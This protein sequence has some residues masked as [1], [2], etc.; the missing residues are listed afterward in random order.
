MSHGC[1]S[2]NNL[3][4]PKPFMSLVRFLLSYRFKIMENNKR[5]TKEALNGS[6]LSCQRLH[7]QE[8][9]TQDAPIS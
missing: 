4:H 5:S 9:A 7:R 3:L 6:A 1:G 2:K 8:G